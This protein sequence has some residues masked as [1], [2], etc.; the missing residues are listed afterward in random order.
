MLEGRWYHFTQQL[1]QSSSS[2]LTKLTVYGQS[3]RFSDWSEVLPTWSFPQLKELALGRTEIALPDL[4]TFLLR[5][6]SISMLELTGISS[7]GRVDELLLSKTDFLPNLEKLIATPEYTIPF[8]AAS[9]SLFLKLKSLE[10]LQ[11]WFT[12]PYWFVLNDYDK[13]MQS[14]AGRTVAYGVVLTTDLAFEFTSSQRERILQWF[15]ASQCTHRLPSVKRLSLQYYHDGFTD[16][17]RC[18]W[19]DMEDGLVTLSSWLKMWPGLTEL[20]VGEELFPGT[21]VREWADANPEGPHGLWDSC[22][23]LQSVLIQELGQKFT[24]PGLE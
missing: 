20:V 9:P 7:V 16:G 17:H 14:I 1:L 12:S 5:H 11:D 8:L 10:I 18:C 6:P 15:T 21:T 3:F 2:S 4:H 19:S 13:L 23:T 22:S 24:R